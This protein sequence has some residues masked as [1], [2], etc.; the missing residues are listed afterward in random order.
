[1]S[2]VLAAVVEAALTALIG[3]SAGSSGQQ[4]RGYRGGSMQSNRGG[5]NRDGA[6]GAT[7][8]VW[9]RSAVSLLL[10]VLKW[11]C[12]GYALLTASAVL[13][14]GLYWLAMPA[15]LIKVPLY[16][17][18]GMRGFMRT[19]EPPLARV[20]LLTRHTQWQLGEHMTVPPK[21]GERVLAAGQQY[22]V[23]L[24]L[25]LPQSPANEKAGVFMLYTRLYDKEKQLLGSSARAAFLPHSSPLLR[26][27][28]LFTL[29]PL[30]L[31]GMSTE[32]EALEVPCFDYL[33]EVV[34]SPMAEAHV[35]LSSPS[36]QVYEAW[37]VI[38]PQLTGLPWLMREWFYT[39][40]IL[41]TLSIALL[42][43]CTGGFAYLILTVEEGHR[44]HIVQPQGGL[45]GSSGSTAQ[46]YSSTQWNGSP[47]NGDGG[48][49]DR[50]PEQ[51]AMG[52]DD[53][54]DHLGRYP[55]DSATTVFA[56]EPL[57]ASR[58]NN[59]SNNNNDDGGGDDNFNFQQHSTSSL[60]SGSSERWS[61]AGLLG[62]RGDSG[63]LLRRRTSNLVDD[64]R[65]MDE[66]RRHEQVESGPLLG[67]KAHSSMGLL[68]DDDSDG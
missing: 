5:G 60:L 36:V 52:H 32:S 41:G 24:E 18:Y 33:E 68:Q 62:G 58:N 1:M 42:L 12:I 45:L 65:Q 51:R 55:S 35:Q 23:T 49:G 53:S 7:L 61:A 17:D 63:G 3:S 6:L 56:S 14:A 44:P 20:D 27:L 50:S 26:A 22:S 16:F 54:G 47:R 48:G 43:A 59:N 29:W 13:Y 4:N 37:L 15:R 64:Q 10:Q 30:Y 38:S 28:R 9:A 66:Y 19:R 67:T 11:L 46:Q 21:V 2:A 34:D 25:S 39:C 40:A 31:M 57:L 8:A